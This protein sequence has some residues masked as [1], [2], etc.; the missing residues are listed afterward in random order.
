MSASGG[1]EKKR[2]NEKE[3]RLKLKNPIANMCTTSGCSRH[4][5]YMNA[6]YTCVVLAAQ[7]HT[8][9]RVAHVGCQRF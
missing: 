3:L 7:K 2:E 4:V 8:T 1:K 6:L 5:G 9:V